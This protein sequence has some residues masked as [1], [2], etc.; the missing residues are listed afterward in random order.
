M[1]TDIGEML[2][3]KLNNPESRKAV[4]YLLENAGTLSGIVEWINTMEDT[5]MAESLKGL[6]YHHT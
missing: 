3:E 1:S 5:G 6:I 2:N 4:E